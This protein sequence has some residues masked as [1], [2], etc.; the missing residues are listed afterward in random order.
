MVYPGSEGQVTPRI[1]IG[2]IGAGSAG[3]QHL[4]GVEA[5]RKAALLDLEV[6]A[7]CDKDDGRL[8]SAAR[9][10]H[11]QNT[12]HDYHDLV[13]DERVDVVYVCT[14]TTMQSDVVK[15]VAAAGKPVLC[16]KPL[17]HSCPQARDLLAVANSAGI[18]TAVA[19]LLRY[20]AFL[21][22]ARRLISSN[23]FG[24]PILA[25]IRDD[26]HVPADYI[27]EQRTSN[28]SVAAGGAILEDSIHDIDVFLWFLGDVERV[29]ATVRFDEE[30]RTEHLASVIL[31]HKN[32]AISTLDSVWHWVDRPDERRVELFFEDGFL[33]ITLETGNRHLDYQLRGE[34]PV[35]VSEESAREALLD[36]LGIRTSTVATTVFV[37]SV[38]AGDERYPALSYAFLT[39]LLGGR[40]SC[41]T[42]KDAVAAHKIIDAAYESASSGH[43]IDP[44]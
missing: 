43:A 20:D 24:R 5:L 44:L 2:L 14:P 36:T 1:G 27:E 13:N 42:F 4:K 34:G 15:A 21:L 40:Q 25:H 32:G 22:Y 41:P 12:Y 39:S 18:A 33:G 16:E 3:L 28:H 38:R 31:T 17:A 6:A 7:L 9:E 8:T 30:R 29:F 37:S 23:E 26:R 35:R 11:P 10:F 19:L